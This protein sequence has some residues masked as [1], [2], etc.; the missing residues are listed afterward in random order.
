MR[1]EEEKI[2]DDEDEPITIKSANVML[3]ERFDYD[4]VYYLPPKLLRQL[5]KIRSTKDAIGPH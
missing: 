4:G 2:L 3:Y 1:F 5:S